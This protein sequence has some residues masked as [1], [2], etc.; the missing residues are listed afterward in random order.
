MT[1]LAS[2]KRTLEEN[3]HYVTRG[4]KEGA[5]GG[6]KHSGGHKSFDCRKANRK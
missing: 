6:K 1:D 4:M 3:L 2:L 5:E